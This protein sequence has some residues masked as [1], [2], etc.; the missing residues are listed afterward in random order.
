M[1]YLFLSPVVWNFY[2]LQNQLLAASLADKGNDVVYLEPVKYKN[3][4]KNSRFMNSD[5]LDWGTP[6]HTY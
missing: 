4:L 3:W 5:P 6:G 1:K 2:K